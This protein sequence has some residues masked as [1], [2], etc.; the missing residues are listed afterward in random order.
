[1]VEMEGEMGDL[2]NDRG[3]KV[4]QWCRGYGQAYILVGKMMLPFHSLWR[5]HTDLP[6]WMIADVSTSKPE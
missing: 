4:G 6:E 1:M 3:S 2:D 5:M